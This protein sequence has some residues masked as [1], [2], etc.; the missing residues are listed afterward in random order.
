MTDRRGFT[1]IEVLVSIVLLAIGLLTMA[2][3]SGGITRT[4]TVS[5]MA[6][7]ASQLAARRLDML[8]A[9]AAA[10]VPNPKCTAAAFASSSAPVVTGGVTESWIV[11]ASGAARQILVIVSYRG[12]NG[13]KTDTVATTISC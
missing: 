3:T 6:T 9:A 4:L 1:L 13:T 8:R 5:R 12:V 10:T 11:P 7:E 2:A